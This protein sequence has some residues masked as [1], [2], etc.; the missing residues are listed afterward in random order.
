VRGAA[1]IREAI[2]NRLNVCPGGTSADGKFTFEPQSI[3]LGACDL[4][5]LV[6][7]EG[8]YY[9][10]VTPEKMDAI[11]TQWEQ[12]GDDTPVGDGLT[13]GHVPHYEE[14]HGFG[15]ASEDLYEGYEVARFMPEGQ[16]CITATKPPAQ[17]SERVQD[18]PPTPN[19]GGATGA[20]SQS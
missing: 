13:G 12:A 2:E 4:S 9:S 1:K 10:F 8:T 6:E 16:Q 11:I 15:P 7:I 3:C 14:N 5:P 17:V 20:Q 19:P 18:T